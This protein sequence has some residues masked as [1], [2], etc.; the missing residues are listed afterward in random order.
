MRILIVTIDQFPYG[1]AGSVRLLSF[2][3]ILKDLGHE[4]I[5]IGQADSQPYISNSYQGFEYISLRSVSKKYSSRLM[6]YIGHKTRLKKAIAKFSESQ[7][8]D[9][10][11]IT[12]LPINSL[13]YLKRLARKNGIK[14]YHDSVEWFSPQNFKWGYLSFFYLINELWNRVLIDQQ[15]SVI[16]ISSFLNNHFN[17]RKIHSIRIP[18]ILDTHEIAFQKLNNSDKLMILY[19]GSPAKKDYLKEV[20]EGMSLLNEDELNQI[21]LNILGA[22]LHQLTNQCGVNPDHIKK[23]KESLQII[24][25]I[26]REEVIKYLHNADFTVL[27]RS[28]ELRYAKAGFPTKIAESLATATPVICNL[29]SDLGLYLKDGKNSIIVE[30]STAQSF[31]IALRKAL[32]LSK[33][34]KQ[35]MCHIARQTAKMHFDFNSY[36]KQLEKFLA[37]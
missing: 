14:L 12:L 29:T 7:K 9:S 3:K 6:N 2:C 20:I 31:V 22:N 16:S 1:D 17:A 30:S 15:F 24:G 33:D 21:K 18:V 37:V 34:E 23:C 10:I 4:V 36:T 8:I 11:L 19:A 13:F 28:S 25:R 5:V 26:Q 35:E 27:L 32:A